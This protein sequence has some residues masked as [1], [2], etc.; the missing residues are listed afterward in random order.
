MCLSRAQTAPTPPG[1]KISMSQPL[2]MAATEH[3]RRLKLQ[4]DAESS[5][6]GPRLQDKKSVDIAKASATTPPT[7]SGYIFEY[8]HGQVRNGTAAIVGHTCAALWL[9]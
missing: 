1:C 4:L 9:L 2:D 8:E 3:I 5:A 6:A 7:A